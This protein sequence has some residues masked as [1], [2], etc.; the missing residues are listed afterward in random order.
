MFLNLMMKT[1][2]EADENDK[3]FY[4]FIDKIEE[5]QRKA[6]TGLVAPVIIDLL[7]KFLLQ[8]SIY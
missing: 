1:E 5:P 7:W 3:I 8:T 4:K 6:F 2:A